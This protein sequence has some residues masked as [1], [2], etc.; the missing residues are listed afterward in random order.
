[1]KRTRGGAPQRV[2]RSHKVPASGDI[3]RPSSSPMQPLLDYSSS[4][5]SAGSRR[6]SDVSSLCSSLPSSVTGRPIYSTASTPSERASYLRAVNSYLA[7]LSPPVHLKPPLPPAR[8][9]TDAIRGLFARIDFDNSISDLTRD[10]PPLLVALRCP[11]KL[12][13]SALKAPSTPHAWPSVLSVLHW[14]VQLALVADHLASSPSSPKVSDY[15]INRY[16]TRAYSLFL[17]GDDCTIAELDA[18]YLDRL[19]RHAA[20]AVKDVEALEVE[21]AQYEAK[22]RDLAAAPSRLEALEAERA[23]LLEDVNKFQNVVDKFSGMIEE[24]REKLAERE[25][26]LETR[27]MEKRRLDEENE[28][29][30]QRIRGQSLSTRDVE[31]MTRE[32]QAVERDIA[33]GESRRNEMEEKAWMLNSELERKFREIETLAEQCNQAIRKLKIGNNFQYVINAKASSAAA[34]I[35]TDYKTMLKPAL[36]SLMEEAN[37]SKVSKVE[38]LINLQ[39]QSLEN[40]MML[41]GKR[42]YCTAI[43]TKIN[44]V[45][46]QIDLLKKE[47]ED[48]ALT[49]SSEIEKIKEELTSKEDQVKIMERDVQELLMESE[50]KLKKTFIESTEETKNCAHELYTLIDSVSQYKEFMGSTIAGIREEI[51]GIAEEVKQA[52]DASIK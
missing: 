49:C 16:I 51:R 26:E 21:V 7:S 46:N 8:D 10:L 29:L 14:L 17:A 45:E 37:K 36:S 44:E 39:K 11:V 30:R 50:E 41:D 23:A 20:S 2:T 22:L 9:I 28:G 18:E 13:K 34:V 15:D 25:R 43:Q 12:S 5:I 19:K 48:H 52:F 40:D 33:E 27:E 24:K 42:A 3:S 32:L 4:I 47:I 6:D 38:E 31:R 35:G 1:M